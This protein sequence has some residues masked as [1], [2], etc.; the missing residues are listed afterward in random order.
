M[1]TSKIAPIILLTLLLASC[2][3]GE[4]NVSNSETETETV[5]VEQ[6]DTNKESLENISTVDASDTVEVLDALSE[7]E[8]IYIVNITKFLEVYGLKANEIRQTLKKDSSDLEAF[9]NEVQG[10]FISIDL[11][12]VLMIEMY[13]EG[14]VPKRFDDT[15]KDLVESLNL[16]SLSGRKL[17]EGIKNNFND[18][19]ILE[20]S[21]LMEE[22]NVSLERVSNEVYKYDN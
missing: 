21:E 11:L 8:A 18:E 10:H 12:K 3:A 22:S 19:L 6:V 14:D 7:E 9:V 4:G 2:D 16:S 5:K 15:H 20:S 13:E 1:K 17:V